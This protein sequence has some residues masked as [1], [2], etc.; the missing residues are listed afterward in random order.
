AVR[1][2]VLFMLALS[3]SACD[4][5][6]PQQPANNSPY[7]RSNMPDQPQP[8]PEALKQPLRGASPT[9]QIAR[10]YIRR[11]ALH[12]GVR[13]QRPQLPPTNRKHYGELDGNP[14]LRV[15]AHPVSTFSIDV[16]TGSYTNVRRLLNAGQLPPTDAVRIE[17]FINYFDYH[18]PLPQ[19]ATQPFSVTTTV[20]PT[21]WNTD[22]ELLRIGIQGWLPASEPA[23]NLVFLVDVSGSM[24]AQNKLPLLKS[25][26][27]LLARHL[28]A[29]D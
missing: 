22:T 7:S 28:D 25:S 5:A 1:F 6:T 17:E 13:L 3:L 15:A 4:T 11:P 9:A 24:R 21:P 14:V 12:G 23:A 10:S 29:D 26:L 8:A 27:K 16:D 2:L 18:Y 19:D 20:A